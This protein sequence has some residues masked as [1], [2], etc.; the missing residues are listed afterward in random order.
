MIFEFVWQYGWE[1]QDVEPQ[2]VQET[3]GDTES[4]TLEE[5]ILNQIIYVQSVCDKY[6]ASIDLQDFLMHQFVGG[7]SSQRSEA[8]ELDFN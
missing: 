4:S 7:F 5:A 8:R 6:G 2:Y 3:H 1:A